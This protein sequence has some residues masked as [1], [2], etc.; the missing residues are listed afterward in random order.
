M[1]GRLLASRRGTIDINVLTTPYTSM[2][3]PEARDLVARI[4]GIAGTP[5]RLPTEKD[6]T[7]R[8]DT[9]TG[10]RLL[11][12]VANPAE[13]PCRIEFQTGLMHHVAHVDPLLPVPAVL[14]S[15]RNLLWEEIRDAVGQN[16]QVWLMSFLAGTPLESTETTS[17]ERAD[18]GKMLARL[19]LAAADFA[20]PAG[21]R[22]LAW[23]SRH[24]LE[25]ADLLEVVADR[26]RRAILTAGFDRIRGLRCRIR[27]LRTQVLHNDFNHSNVLV[28][29]GAPGFVTGIVDFGDAVRTA[30]AIDV[31]IALLDQLPRGAARDPTED[32]FLAARD[33]LRGYLSVADLN[34][35]ELEL[36]PHLIMARLMARALITT[37]RA[38]LFPG[39][40]TYILRNT[41]QAWPL[42][43]WFLEHSVDYVSSVLTRNGK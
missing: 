39:N 12:K 1:R 26:R 24:L 6:D 17:D 10:R 20:H 19:R 18:I 43:E 35:E 16:R 25:L 21:S 3:E 33:V 15:R 41:R 5:T 31:A 22:V 32:L 34:G 8:V 27:A 11:L 13:D 30:V 37:W 28:E 9:A 2:G 38:S 42:L 40:A 4:Y 14:R 23:D 29:R 36:I 7:F